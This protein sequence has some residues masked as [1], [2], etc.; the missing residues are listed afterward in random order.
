MF[1]K[2][3][4][5]TAIFLVG[6]GVGVGVRVGVGVKHIKGVEY[7]TIQPDTAVKDKHF[8]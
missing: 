7:L 6:V 4:N 1:T 5:W 3:A 8:T 2:C